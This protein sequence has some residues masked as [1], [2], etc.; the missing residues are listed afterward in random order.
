MGTIASPSM[1]STATHLNL[2]TYFVDARL[3]AGAGDRIA[4]REGDRLRTYREVAEASARAAH[5][6]AAEGV[7]PEERVIIALPDGAMFVETL[8][9]ILRHGAVVVMVTSALARRATA[10]STT[11]W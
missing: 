3:D 11:R 5:L 6:L 9:G 10:S 8:F 4:I 1:T 7:R 2:A